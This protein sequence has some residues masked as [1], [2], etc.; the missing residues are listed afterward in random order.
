[1]I[2]RDSPFSEVAWNT[3]L[4]EPD[5]LT[6]F[7]SRRAARISS[8]LAL[9]S[10]AAGVVT[11]MRTW[12]P[13]FRTSNRSAAGSATAQRR[14]VRELAGIKRLAFAQADHAPIAVAE[15]HAVLDSLVLPI[16]HAAI[17]VYQERGADIAQHDVALAHPV[18]VV[19]LVDARGKDV[20]SPFAGLTIPHLQ[21]AALPY[22]A[23]NLPSGE[24][25]N[26]MNSP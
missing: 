1:M 7:S 10:G 23:R 25:A 16:D 3:S 5:C 24:N 2:E 17:H 20:A 6:P 11:S 13:G 12:L 15:H 21:A 22:N 8:I 4:D 18:D 14:R 26:F 19:R 9:W